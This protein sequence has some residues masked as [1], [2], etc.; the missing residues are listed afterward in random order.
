MH[1]GACKQY[2]F[3]SYS[4]STFSAVCFD[5]NPSTF[6]ILHF[7]ISVICKW[8]HGSEGFKCYINM[9]DTQVL[10]V[11]VSNPSLACQACK[12]VHH[13]QTWNMKKYHCPPASPPVSKYPLTE[14]CSAV[15]GSDKTIHFGGHGQV[16]AS[17]VLWAL[18]VGQGQTRVQDTLI[19]NLQ[20]KAQQGG[21]AACLP[22]NKSPSAPKAKSI[23]T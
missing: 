3:W 1:T 19:D 15:L 16:D 20:Q 9:G 7:Y 22:T 21:A 10:N 12:S 4:T 6:Q 14:R 23:Y 2:I 11:C 13:D 8:H 18:H 5:E 17:F